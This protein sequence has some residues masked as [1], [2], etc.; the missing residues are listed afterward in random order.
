MAKDVFHAQSKNGKL[1]FGTEYNKN[2]FSVFL[3]ENDGVRIKIIP[4]TD[5]SYNKRK[6]FEGAIVPFFAL[7]HLVRDKEGN[8]KI[9]SYEEARNCLK[10][11][12]NPEYARTQDGE[13]VEIAGSS[14]KLNN[15]EFTERLIEQPLTYMRENG[16]LLP[17]EDDYKQWRDS[18]PAV[19]EVYPPIAR[20][21]AEAK[22]KVK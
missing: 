8:P 1:Y 11:W 20:L 6:F 18:A 17:N 2:R 7:Q 9:M 10:L 19:K 16:F 12:F 13:V 22:E 14:K 4:N 5:I 15:K 3:K 21:L